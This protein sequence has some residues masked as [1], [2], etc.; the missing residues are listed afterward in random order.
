MSCPTEAAGTERCFLPQPYNC[1][2]TLPWF[3]S[4][5]GDPRTRSSACQPHQ[6][7]ALGLFTS[8]SAS[9]GLS[10]SGHCSLSTSMIQRC[11]TSSLSGASP[12]KTWTWSRREA[13]SPGLALL[14]QHMLREAEGGSVW[15]CTSHPALRICQGWV[16]VGFT[17]TK[18]RIQSY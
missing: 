4:R 3:L 18:N 13:S 7:T 14:S 16:S 10:W 1:P 12:G 8:P 6:P 17:F 2:L 11:S 5:T 9:T 15:K